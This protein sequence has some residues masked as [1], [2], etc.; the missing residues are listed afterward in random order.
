VTGARGEPFEH[1]AA[2]GSSDTR[3]RVGNG[4]MDVVASSF[5]TEPDLPA[6]GA[7]PGRVVEEVGQ[8]LVQAV[9]IC[10]NNEVLG[11][12]V[13]RIAHSVRAGLREGVGKDIAEPNFLEPQRSRTL[14][15]AGK[16]EQVPY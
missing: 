9:G 4:E 6:R 14:L 15:D 12:H 10:G 11:P 7:V 2:V 3:S 8:Q 5:G 16:V 13:D 1:G